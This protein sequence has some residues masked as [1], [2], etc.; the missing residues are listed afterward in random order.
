MINEPKTLPTQ[1]MLN[2]LF[3]YD[4]INLV[5]RKARG[6]LKIGDIVGS[7]DVRKG[8]IRARVNNKAYLVHRL[9]WKLIY[10]S[11]PSSE[12]DHINGVRHDNRLDNLRLSSKKDNM[13][14]ITKPYKSKTGIKGITKIKNN[15]FK[16]LYYVDGKMTYFGTYKNLKEATDASRKACKE[17][18]RNFIGELA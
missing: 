7:K 6:T 11:E 12:I 15:I 8:Y 13:S 3:D 2:E 10:G 16:V 1:E 17:L 9:I 4:G 14:N 18:G 5:A